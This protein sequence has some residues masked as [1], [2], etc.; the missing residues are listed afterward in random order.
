MAVGIA[1]VPVVFGLL[2]LFR[3]PPFLDEAIYSGWTAQI[4]ES[5]SERF[6]PLAS[7]KEPLLGWLAAAVT[8][9]GF[10]PF[11]AGRLVS[12]ASACGTVVLVGALG[13]ILGGRRVALASGLLAATCP[14]LVVYGALGL[15]ESLAT[16]LVTA[17]LLLQIL[18]V[19]TLRA[20]VALLLGTSLGLGLL[21]KQS[22]LLALVL[23][24]VSLVL[25]DVSSPGI[26]NRLGR[27]A[28]LALLAAAVSFVIYSILRLSE[29]HNDLER[30]R[31][32]IYPVHSAHEALSKP[33][34]WLEQ[35]WPAYRDV[36]SGYVTPAVILAAAV[37]VGLGL[38]RKAGLT[39][40][41]TAWAL[42]MLVTAALLADLPFPRYV[43]SAVPPLLVIAGA[44]CVWT[45]DALAAALRRSERGLRLAP[46]SLLL[47]L[48]IALLHPLLFDA[49]LVAS[50]ASVTY[51]G[52]DDEQLVTGWAAGTGL[53]AARRALESRAGQSGT[54][55]VQLGPQSPSWL[56]YA[57]RED[58]RFRFVPPDA[59]DPSALVAIEN[60]RPLP[61]RTS[62]L[63]W[64]PIRRIER[65]RDGVPV[66]LYE[67][68]VRLG[69]HV[70]AS[71]EVLRRLIVPDARFD[72]Y[73]A[74]HPAVRSW[75]EAWYSA[76]G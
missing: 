18:L 30:L 40:V 48:G 67:A 45:A 6:V 59:D 75:V 68:G 19:R 28:G 72:E 12:L 3:F 46:L 43:H 49:R 53:K 14:F 58:S 47:V 21:T 36:L 16:F 8:T 66:V 22:T 5:E 54:V 32:E 76:H 29:F 37:G 70:V 73:V 38:R 24:P 33:G 60:G 20:D 10:S 26:A 31:D 44:G 25:L 7:G 23:W 13:E 65:P 17:S 69:G 42:V 50:P 4:A 71:P 62:P 57:M 51:P 39:I 11:T 52:F 34:F 63:S 9:V 2:L 27:F 1:A 35:N 74:S 15:Y 61:A 64:R 41:L 55:V 56:T